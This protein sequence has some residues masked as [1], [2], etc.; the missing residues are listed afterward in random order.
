MTRK[1]EFQDWAKPLDVAE[2]RRSRNSKRGSF[3][4]PLFATLCA[5]LGG[6][7]ADPRGVPPGLPFSLRWQNAVGP[8]MSVAFAADGRRGLAVGPDGAILAT[9][10]GGGQWEPKRGG[11]TNHLNGVAIAANGGL[12]WA[13]GNKGTILATR[14]AG[15]RW[16]SQTSGV[17]NNLGG[18][19]FAA[20]GRTGWAVGDKGTILATRNGGERWEPQTSGTSNDLYGVAFAADGRTG[21]AVGNSGTIL[22]TRNGGDQWEPQNSGTTNYLIGIAFAADGRI[23]WAVG[24]NG[25]ILVTRNGGQQWEPQVSGTTNQLDSVA[26]A[27]DGR[28][29]WAV[30][31]NGT[32]LATHDGGQ[33]WQAQTSGTTYHLGGVALAADGRFGWVVGDNG[34]IVATRDGGEQW[35]PQNHDTT[36]DLNGVTFATDGQAG[37]IVGDDG[38]ILTT[39]DGGDQWKPQISGTSSGLLGVAFTGDGRSGW[40]VGYKGTI[41]GTHDGGDHW[42]AQISG[43]PNDLFSVVF[44]A[45]GQTGWAVGDKGTILATRNGGDQWQPQISGTTNHL[46]RVVFAADGRTGWAV[47]DSGTILATRDGGNQWKAQISSTTNNLYGL[48]CSA[49]RRVCWAAGENATILTTFDGGDRWTPLTPSDTHN[50]PTIYSLAF[51]ADGRSGWAVVGMGGTGGILATRNAGYPWKPET[52]LIANELYDV[53][54]ADSVRTAWAIGKNGTIIR[55]VAAIPAAWA[56][57]AKTELVSRHFKSGFKEQIDLSFAVHADPR[58]PVKNAFV[59]ERV[60]YRTAWNMLGP[61]EK[62]ADGSGRMHLI[63]TPADYNIRLGERVSCAVALD[64]GGPPIAP[65]MIAA[66]TFDPLWTRMWQEDRSATVGFA[67]AL[68]ILLLYISAFGLVLVV[69]PARLAGVG[70]KLP[71]DAANAPTGNLGFVWQF[72]RGTFERVTLP[73]MCRLPR[74]RR[75]WIARY[76][77]GQ[78]RLRDLGKP[79][80]DSFLMNSEVLDAW[81]IERLARVERALKGFGHYAQRPFYIECPVRIGSRENGRLIERP[82]PATLRDAFMRPRSIVT[83]VGPGGAGKSTL[84]CAIA[85]WAM[86]TDSEI[87]LLPHPMLPVFIVQETTNLIAD[88]TRCLREM[89]GD[90]ELPDDLVRG[91]LSQQR[92]LVI[93]DALSERDSATQDYIS[94]IFGENPILNAF[95]VTSRSEPRLGATERTN[96]FPLL[97]DARRVVP[98]IVDYLARLETVEALQSGRVQLRLGEQILALAESSGQKTPV[99]PLLVKLF[100]DSAIGRA[101]KGLTLDDMPHAIPEVFVDYL[102]RLSSGDTGETTSKS[103]EDF[104]AAA[105]VLAEVSLGANLVPGDFTPQQASE[106]LSKAEEVGNQPEFLLNR[107]IASG[108][109]ERRYLAGVPILRFSLDPVADYLAAIRKIFD[110]RSRGPSAIDLYLAELKRIEDYPQGCDGYLV[111]FATCYEAYLTQLKLP[112]LHFPWDSEKRGNSLA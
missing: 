95:V 102:R 43:T 51:A 36:N 9:R 79:A 96:L 67:F 5:L 47:G 10:N 78:V 92:L 46:F 83:I 39:R 17:T 21:W 45:D 69:A 23:G 108:V 103:D 60:G 22:I 59:L 65:T 28:V 35:A 90:E 111:A 71:L 82:S 19:A 68:G 107:L 97:L 48:A 7:G 31:D 6:L 86:S 62:Q 37:W 53:T 89:L 50:S 34:T 93:V 24:E 75:A 18:I 32:I 58:A 11:T 64:D 57:Q 61:A 30:G 66:I 41:L 105:K 104:I 40:A 54:F 29:G 15:D 44:A 99:T 109:I 74:V 1:E 16:E 63:W 27:A 3:L 4:I 106:A 33:K 87:R 8:L 80:R 112:K 77:S 94:G 84:A 20:D 49:H 13:V 52:D 110:L 55:S 98:F 26:L 81:V 14:N 56:D 38:T 91:L 72:A 85:R 100:V 101:T 70:G 73:W 42:K 12:G 76:R 2:E 88:V 25:T